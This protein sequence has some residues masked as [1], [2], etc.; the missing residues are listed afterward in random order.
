MRTVWAVSLLCLAGCASRPP[1]PAPVAHAAEFL[2]T[3]A[4]AYPTQAKLGGQQG[5]VVVRAWLEP[6]GD[7]SRAAVERSSGWPALDM[8][9]MQGVSNWK[10]LPGRGADGRA[11][12]T[13]AVPVDFRLKE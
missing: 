3:P 13:V 11:I 8:A 6:D 12:D 4:P 2:S 9:A 10:I 7:V 5:R 1:A